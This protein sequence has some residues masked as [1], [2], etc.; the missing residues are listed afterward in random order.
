MPWNDNNSIG[1]TASESTTSISGI[2]LH[3][4]YNFSFDLWQVHMNKLY[5]ISLY[6]TEIHANN[7]NN[8]NLLVRF[9][10]ITL[11]NA[12]NIGQIASKLLKKYSVRSQ[13]VI[14]CHIWHIFFFTITRKT[15][16]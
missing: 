12:T 7:V 4:F 3:D 13:T 16:Q 15:T 9:T 6:Q 14:Q 8:V 5:D 2:I 11:K 10:L 1:I